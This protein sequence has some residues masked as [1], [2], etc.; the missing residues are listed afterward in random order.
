MKIS[1][2]ELKVM[3]VIWNKKKVTSAEIIKELEE[4]K[5]SDNTIRTLITRLV[6][7]KA[8]EIG[9]KTGKTYEYIPL[10]DEKRYKAE[11][12]QKNLNCLFNGSISECLIILA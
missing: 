7:K 8:V 4:C 5:W 12:F 3:Q 10:I 2:A 9:K 11:I 1:D 6:T